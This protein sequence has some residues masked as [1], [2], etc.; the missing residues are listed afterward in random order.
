[1]P[2]NVI[3]D[4]FN[5]ERVALA[6]AAWATYQSARRRVWTYAPHVERQCFKTHDVEA[7]ARGRRLILL[8]KARAARAWLAAVRRIFGHDAWVE[9]VGTTHLGMPQCFL[10]RVPKPGRRSLHVAERRWGIPPADDLVGEERILF[11]RRARAAAYTESRRDE[12]HA[13]YYRKMLAALT[14]SRV[15]LGLMQRYRARRST[16]PDQPGL[17]SLL[18]RE[19]NKAHARCRDYTR[20]ALRYQAKLLDLGYAYDFATIATPFTLPE[21]EPIH[22]LTRRVQPA[23]SAPAAGPEHDPTADSRIAA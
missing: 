22:E 3:F 21:E 8:V 4:P 2:T 5:A 13:T 19:A 6:D 15:E 7:Y 14:Q 11:E 17:R 16:V 12:R 23:L 18:T 20:R 9:A 10:V 1:M